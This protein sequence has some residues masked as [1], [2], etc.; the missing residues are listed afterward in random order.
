M[1]RYILILIAFSLVA[2]LPMAAGA[3]VD[4]IVGEGTV[5]GGVYPLDPWDFDG[6]VTSMNAAAGGSVTFTGTFH[7]VDENDAW[8]FTT[9]H[10]LEE[11]W[12]AGSTPFANLENPDDAAFTSAAVVAGAYDSALAGFADGVEMWLARG[13]G[14]S[15]V[16][17]PMQEMNGDWVSYGADPAN[18]Q[19][20]FAHVRSVMEGRISDDT[21]VRW[22]FAPNGWS[23]P[24]YGGIAA[25]Y[26]GDEHVD[27]IT[28]STY[29]F[30]ET[31]AYD[32][33]EPVSVSVAPFVDEVIS[34]IGDHKPMMLSQTASSSDG[35]DKDQWIRDLFDYVSDHPNLVG[36]VYFNKNKET[37]W[38][39]WPSGAGFAGWSDSI[40]AADYQWPLTN[41]FQPGPLP[42]AGAEPP[43]PLCPDAMDC[44][45]VVLVTP[46]S[47]LRLLDEVMPGAGINQ[48][49]FGTP[50]DVPLM[51]DW[52]GD[53]VAT[54]G[55]YR[56]SNGFAYIRYSNDLGPGDEEFFYG[57]PGD[58]P[59]V[60][61]W[62]GDGKDTL[63]IY[64]SGEVFVRN[65]LGTGPA[66]F[67]FY[68]GVPGD[69][70][71]AGDF[72]GDGDDSV[73]LYR[74]SSGYVYFRNSLNSGVADFEFF[75]GAPSDR[76]LA[77]DWNGNGKDT[78]AVYRP[79]SGTIYFRLTNTQGT[80]D[81]T[82]EVGTGFEHASR[83]R[84]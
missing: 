17:A 63:A 65:E 55:M 13:G 66:E 83:L 4:P 79:T 31:L 69:R 24:G 26:P 59:L 43:A 48:F 67:S 40:S 18:Y 39:I 62:D 25:Y 1:R 12:A 20:A 3:D 45:S 41:W 78:V 81:Y 42:F 84:D 36:M 53:G 38:A 70:P 15:L 61:D 46:G 68:Y 27:L 72:D 80:A 33:W 52:N 71:F 16:M 37:D 73:G 7:D 14:R 6:E 19:L 64:R 47:Q 44:D 76:I 54:P 22:A 29:N 82:L 58:V 28:L 8:A 60:G 51:G 50:E 30:G 2:A 35:G 56:P 9:D 75:Y 57:I 21:K 49:Y 77:G 5:L 11:A 32:G 23:T 74:E 34:S 10:K